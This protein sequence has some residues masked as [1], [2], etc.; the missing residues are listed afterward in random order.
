MTEQEKD[1]LLLAMC[2]E[3]F[4]LFDTIEHKERLKSLKELAKKYMKSLPCSEGIRH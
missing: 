2:N 1:E 4:I 3:I